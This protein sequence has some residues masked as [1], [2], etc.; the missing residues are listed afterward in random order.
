MI[1]T[2]VQHQHLLSHDLFNRV[3]AA[4]LN[5][6]RH[7]RCIMHHPLSALLTQF[8]LE[9]TEDYRLIGPVAKTRLSCLPIAYIPLSWSHRIFLVL[10]SRWSFSSHLLVTLDYVWTY[11]R[12]WRNVDPE[13]RVGGGGGLVEGR[14]KIVTSPIL[15]AEVV[16]DRTSDG[17]ARVH[18]VFELL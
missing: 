10:Q 12:G 1:M 14:K 2:K 6:A 11:S 4:N 8:L 7:H 5:L 18:G 15:M 9:G 17:F 3:A 16:A 13:P